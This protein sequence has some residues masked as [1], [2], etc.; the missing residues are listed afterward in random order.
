VTEVIGWI[1]ERA[2]RSRGGRCSPQPA[3]EAQGR[4]KITGVARRLALEKGVD[5]ATVQGSGPGGRI[6][7][8]DIEKA[9]AAAGATAPAATP[10]SVPAAARAPRVRSSEPLKGIRKLI[11]ERL[12]ASVRSIPQVTLTAVLDAGPLVALKSG[13]R[14]APAT[15]RRSGRPSR[16]CW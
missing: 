9:A 11:A 3:S 1:G 14:P 12:T 7:L 5:I 2:S 6:V 16:T 8:Q 15:R 4:V 10:A 13:C